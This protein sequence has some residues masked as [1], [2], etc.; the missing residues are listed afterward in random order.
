MAISITE[1][2]NCFKPEETGVN[3]LYKTIISP[4]ILAI[5]AHNAAISV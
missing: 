3:D 4:R 5:W 1:C 2:K